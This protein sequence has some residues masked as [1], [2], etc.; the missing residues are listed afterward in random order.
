MMHLHDCASSNARV[1]L[2]TVDSGR[3]AARLELAVLDTHIH[4]A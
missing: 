2:G 4:S 1:T 3:T